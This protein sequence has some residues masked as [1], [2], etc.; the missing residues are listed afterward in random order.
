[1]MQ[2]SRSADVAGISAVAFIVAVIIS[3]AYYQ[4]F[5]IPEASRRP[6]IPQEVLEPEEKIAG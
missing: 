2:R 3:L 5:Y 1:M 4:F 6:V